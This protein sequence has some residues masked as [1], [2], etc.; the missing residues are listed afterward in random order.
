MACGYSFFVSFFHLFRKSW[1]TSCTIKFFEIVPYHICAMYPLAP[2]P[3]GFI[4]PNIP[5]FIINSTFW[6]LLMTYLVDPAYFI[7]L[8]KEIFRI[9]TTQCRLY[10]Y[11]P[12]PQLKM[13]QGQPSLIFAETFRVIPSIQIP[14]RPECVQTLH[15][16]MPSL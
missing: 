1:C 14:Y 13:F 4:S 5:I 7:C 15:I 16:C 12:I 10:Q 2:E 9:L 6:Y 3:S 11:R 8:L